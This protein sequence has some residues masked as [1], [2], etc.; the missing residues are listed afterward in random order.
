[1]QDRQITEADERHRSRG[2]R[3]DRRGD[4]D[5]AIPA[6]ATPDAVH[7]PVL[8]GSLE[9]GE[10]ILFTLSAFVAE[11]TLETL[12][13]E[14]GASVRQRVLDTLGICVAADAEGLGDGTWDL[15]ELWG[16]REESSVVGHAGRFPAPQSALVNGTL[17]HSLDFDDT[18]LPS[19]LHPSASLVPAVLAQAEETGASGADAI[20]A[21][22]ALAA[23]SYTP[24]IFMS[25]SPS[26]SR[27]SRPPGTAS[28]TRGI[29]G[30]TAR[31]TQR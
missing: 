3:A 2:H 30:R 31:T 23:L 13:A 9:G 15:V 19:V 21:A 8:E 28:R 20:A 29:G 7:G 14:V 12:P 1:M 5:R 26:W 27:V 10:T 6:P 4:A 24:R 16:G 25:P 11:T 22:A 17:A 18:H